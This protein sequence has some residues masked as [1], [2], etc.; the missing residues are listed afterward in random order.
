MIGKEK[1]NE[2]QELSYFEHLNG[3]D[4]PLLR[5]RASR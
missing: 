1:N 3:I 2:E 4:A 5:H